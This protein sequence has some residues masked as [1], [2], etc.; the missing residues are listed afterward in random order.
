MPHLS[1]IIVLFIILSQ[2]CYSQNNDSLKN[3]N[4]RLERLYKEDISLVKNDPE[5][6]REIAWKIINSASKTQYQYKGYGYYILG[7]SFFNQK[8]YDVALKYY[9]QANPYFTLLNDSVNIT[10][11]LRNIGL[12]HLYKS[13]YNKALSIY[14]QSLAI[15]EE[16]NDSENIAICY[17]NMG[18]ALGELNKLEMQQ[19]Y[20]KKALL[21]YTKQK[22]ETSIAD[23]NLNLGHCYIKLAQ[24]NKAG[25][26]Y[27]NALSVYK[28][29]QDSSKIA[30]VYGNLGSLY[31]KQDQLEEAG[32]YYD[33]SGEL[34]TKI[35]DKTGLINTYLGLGNLSSKKGQKETAI[36]FYTKSEKLNEKVEITKIRMENLSN[37]YHSYKEIKEFEKANILLEKYYTLKDSIYYTNQND[38]VI[39]L[40]NKYLF[41]KNKN[42][43][44]EVTASNRLYILI[45]FAI[46]FIVAIGLTIGWFYFSTKRLENKQRQL[47]LEQKVLRTQMNPHFLFNSLSAIQCYI[48]EN[49]TLDAVE[50]LAEF[51]GLMR[52]VLQY[53]QNEYI[54][55]QQE[56]E[57]LDYYIKLQNR[58][59]GDKVD[60]EI[61]IDRDIDTARVQVPP[62]LGQPFIE[63]SFEHGNIINKPDGKITVHFIRKDK[64]LFYTIEDNGIG[65]NNINSK[66]VNQNIKKHKSLAIKITK[67]RLSLM[68]K[69]LFSDK[70]NLIVL[71]KTLQGKEGTKVEFT[72]PLLETN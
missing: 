25:E 35:N 12:I 9:N 51:A 21:L 5:K 63:N 65:I 38:K 6:A 54:I 59:F 23:I 13:D 30:S 56:I 64:K 72:L 29:V 2:Q 68:N 48:L 40:E 62:M 34:Y 11:T 15:S 32:Y 52:M 57:I 58:R 50:F 60:Y 17:Q 19:T 49:K 36:E 26:Y 67:E 53:S 39:K 28:K 69:G 8:N 33:L 46:I 16:M 14:E 44:A 7:E 18:I 55:L 22:D 66:K 20:Y 3:I 24:Y 37:L 31:L 45:I 10:Q 42:K 61:I 43:L 27:K 4:S 41:Q 71:D 70:V 1:H 47:S